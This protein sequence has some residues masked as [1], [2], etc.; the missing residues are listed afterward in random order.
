MAPD[1]PT[2]TGADTKADDQTTD[3]T[4]KDAAAS[5]AKSTDDKKTETSKT[6]DDFDAKVLEN[7]A[8]WKHPRMQEL[9][10]A[11]KER[12]D[13][14]TKQEEAENE[15]LKSEKKFEELATKNGDKVKDLQEKLKQTRI[16]Q[17]LTEKLS[18]SGVLKVS[19]ALKLVDRTKL[20]VDENGNVQGVDG[21]VESL[22]KEESYL[23]NKD[24]STSRVG[25]ATNPGNNS[26]KSKTTTKKFTESQIAAMS[27]KEYAENRE[28]ILAAH[29]DGNVEPDT[30]S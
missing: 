25:T 15:R 22:Q 6:T 27:E 28:D 23:F 18:E 24:G 30:S 26:D 9:L 1:A 29:K 21:A 13:L 12:D 4:G 20:D 8:L 5:D 17:A 16:D 14:K 3:T 19:S 10:A 7:E 11:K 2:Q